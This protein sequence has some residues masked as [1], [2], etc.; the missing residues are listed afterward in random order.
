MTQPCWIFRIRILV[1][2]ASFASCLTAAEKPNILF[3]LTDDQGCSSLGC[4]GNEE[5]STP[6][7][8]RFA[9]EGIRFTNA[10]VTS[11]CTPT[12]A[13][14][15][16]G[17]HSARNGMWHVIGWYGYPWAPVS[18]PPFVESLPPESF[19]IAKGLRSAGY[20]TTCIGKW[21]LTNSRYGN[22]LALNEKDAHLFGFDEAPVP[23]SWDYQKVGDKGVGWL[24][25]EA[26]D[27]IERKKDQP[28]FVY[29]SHHTIHGPVV[30]PEETVQKY[31]DLGFPE[32]GLNHAHYLAA[33]ETLDTGVGRLLDGLESMGEADETILVFLGDNG[34]VDVQYDPAQFKDG[35]G[36]VE[37]LQVRERHFSSAP[38]RAGKG[39]QYEG[40]IRVPC[41][42]RWPQGFEGG[43]V[44]NTP[45]HVTDWLPT[46]LAAAAAETPDDWIVDGENLLPLWRGEEFVERPIYFY[47][48]LYDLRWALTPC[49]IIRE[50]KWKLIDYFGD[51]VDGEGKYLR[52][53]KVELFDLEEDPGETN[54]LA[55]VESEIAEKL[56]EQLR[57]W[58][59]SVPVPIPE[60][61]PHHD[62]ERPLKETREKPDWYPSI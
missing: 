4:Y 21:H 56:Q 58:M 34:G 53:A 6:N 9:E 41:L 60:E 2:L 33:I 27:F 43:R 37:Q 55:S 42:V 26:L 61:N 3:I 20:A 17:Q 13:S 18:E 32:R 48:P 16:T 29:L 10:Y 35:S 45:V 23:P 25:D 38:L 46:F 49:A 51:S 7:L 47:M 36:K 57:E 28:W 22:Y 8:D 19:T 40:G 30:A 59:R 1:V 12:R 14:L 54:D 11:Q 62:P 15:L 52:G 5:V 24:T 31:R 39:S 44:E 50:G